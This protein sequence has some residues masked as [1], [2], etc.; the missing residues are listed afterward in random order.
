MKWSIRIGSFRG[1]G[2]YIHT[3]FLLLLAFL[4]VSSY[5]ASGSP[6]AAVAGVAFFV[7]LFGCILLHEF[8]HALAAARYGVRTRD[9][10]LL[11]IGGLARLEQI[12]EDPRK[13]LVVAAAGPL[14]NIVIALGLY[15]WLSAT[16]TIAPLSRLGM[17][18]GPFLQR[19]MVFNVFIVVFNLIPAF[20]MDGGRMLRALLALRMEYVRATQVAA[21]VGQ[22]L[23]FVF[24]FIGLFANPWLLFI[25]FFVW[26]GAAQEASMVQMKGALGGIPLQTLMIRDFQSLA[27]SDTL[28]RAVELTLAGSQKDFPVTENGRIVGILTQTEMLRALQSSGPGTAVGEAMQTE[29]TTAERGEMMEKVFTR[30]QTCNCRTLPVTDHGRLIGLITMEN[31]GEFLQIQAALG[32]SAVPR[33]LVPAT[34]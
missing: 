11:P 3:T 25:A 1:I 19:L 32:G 27:P 22:A 17:A 2:V 21:S 33:R 12:P 26:I 20:P 16:G 34:A 18:G 31:V 24:G 6:A 10:T 13:E 7:L 9:I 4:A 5:M 14:V 29:F 30:L 15:G 23:A 8:G 28:A